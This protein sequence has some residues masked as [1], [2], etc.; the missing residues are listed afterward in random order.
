M[1]ALSTIHSHEAHLHQPDHYSVLSP[2]Y[3]TSVPYPR[4]NVDLVLVQT[5]VKS[6]DLATFP[7]T[8]FL[9][10]LCG[11]VTFVEPTLASLD[12]VTFPVTFCSVPWYCHLPWVSLTPRPREETI[13][14]TTTCCLKCICNNHNDI[15]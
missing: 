3:L 1:S 10:F 4:Y 14:Y 6:L 12:T 13:C 2:P 15:H 5:S 9:V 11:C 8:T 7:V